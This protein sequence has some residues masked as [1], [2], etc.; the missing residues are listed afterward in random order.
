MLLENYYVRIMFLNK[1]LMI[2]VESFAKRSVFVFC[3][4]V[5]DISVLRVFSDAE[6][7]G[8][9]SGA[10]GTMAMLPACVWWCFDGLEKLAC[11]RR[12]N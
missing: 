11:A 10:D 8:G 9:I 1:V 12:G 4:K 5:S 6:V 7:V 2:S 3:L